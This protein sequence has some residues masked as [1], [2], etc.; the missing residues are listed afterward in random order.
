MTE[1]TPINRRTLP[2]ELTKLIDEGYMDLKGK[3]YLPVAYRILWF[4][5]VYP[6]WSITTEVLDVGPEMYVFARLGYYSDSEFRTVSTGHKRV[7]AGRKGPAGVFPLE[8]AETG[9]IGRALALAGFGTLAGDLI[10]GDQLSDAPVK[11]MTDS[12]V[13]SKL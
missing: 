8:T 13:R 10:E 5:H 9:A 1:I 3:D 2:F 7:V 4:R 12:D 6:D 11:R